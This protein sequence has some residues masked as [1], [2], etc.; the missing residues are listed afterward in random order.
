MGWLECGT[1]WKK[2]DNVDRRRDCA[3]HGS[4]LPT[5]EGFHMTY[6]AESLGIRVSGAKSCQCEALFPCM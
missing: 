2:F 1:A 4:R 3:S 5:N 6:F